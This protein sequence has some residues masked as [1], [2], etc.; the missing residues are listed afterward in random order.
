M[1]RPSSALK[2]QCL[3][4]LI[5]RHTRALYIT[6]EYSCQAMIRDTKVE[7]VKLRPS[8]VLKLQ[9][10]PGISHWFS[11]QV[12]KGD[13]KA[14]YTAILAQKRAQGVSEFVAQGPPREFQVV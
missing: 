4:N 5:M 8:S 7:E 9:C 1:L 6:V 10:E 11:P 3:R 12:M 13:T 14:G 2:L